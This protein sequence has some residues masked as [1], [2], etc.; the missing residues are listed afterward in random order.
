MKDIWALIVGLQRVDQTVLT[1]DASE[2]RQIPFATATASMQNVATS[3]LDTILIQVDK[4][5]IERS[6]HLPVD[7][8]Y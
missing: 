6:K 7:I 2:H 3:L 8:A 1:L 4:N 5:K